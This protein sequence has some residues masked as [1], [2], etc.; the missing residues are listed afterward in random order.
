MRIGEAL[1]SARNVRMPLPF[2]SLI[3]KNSAEANDALEKMTSNQHKD[4][5]GKTE[6]SA[7]DHFFY[8]SGATPDLDDL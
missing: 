2:T 4:L 6:Q 1:P 5:E 7:R 3:C 8:Y